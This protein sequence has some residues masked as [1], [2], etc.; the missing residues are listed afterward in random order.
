AGYVLGSLFWEHRGQIWDPL[1]VQLLQQN[2]DGFQ[3]EPTTGFGDVQVDV[4]IRLAIGVL[5][6][7]W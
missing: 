3:N 1:D 4:S 6:F 5:S 2:I 7:T